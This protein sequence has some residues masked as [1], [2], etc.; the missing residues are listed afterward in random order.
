MV[1]H[2]TSVV[3][4]INHLQAEVKWTINLMIADGQLQSSLGVCVG[5]NGLT[6]YFVTLKGRENADRLVDFFKSESD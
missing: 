1:H 5:K 6:T 2:D 3:G 4:Y